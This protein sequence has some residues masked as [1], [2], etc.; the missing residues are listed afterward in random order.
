MQHK[1]NIFKLISVEH[2]YT[3]ETIDRGDCKHLQQGADDN[4]VGILTEK[5]C[6]I[7]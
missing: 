1:Q 3:Q 6:N 7:R 5:K 4:V 2:V